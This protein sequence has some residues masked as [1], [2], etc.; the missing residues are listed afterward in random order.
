MILLLLLCLLP[1]VAS[2]SRC[3]GITV[4]FKT[5]KAK[6]CIRAIPPDWVWNDKAAQG[7]LDLLPSRS[8]C[9]V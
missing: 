2:G 6:V 5:R 3:L 7:C 4:V 1:K 8:L 9:S